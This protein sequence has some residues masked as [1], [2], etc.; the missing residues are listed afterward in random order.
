MNTHPPL[1]TGE[2]FCGNVEDGKPLSPSLQGLEVV[3]RKPA[4]EV[5]GKP[6]EGYSA[7]ILTEP[8]F[9]VYNRRQ[10]ARL[11]A[12]RSGKGSR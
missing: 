8:G 7:V 10:E 4:F 12:I 2:R 11:E 5:T 9:A 6:L 3:L 1:E